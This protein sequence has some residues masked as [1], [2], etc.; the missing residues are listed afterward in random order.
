MVDRPERRLRATPRP[1]TE[2]LNVSGG[3]TLATKVADPGYAVVG[4]LWDAATAAAANPPTRT[5]SYD[6]LGLDMPFDTNQVSGGVFLNT[7]V[8]IS[9]RTGSVTF[10]GTKWGLWTD[11]AASRFR[12]IHIER[13]FPL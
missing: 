6:Q 13:G 1:P 5:Y 12:N 3:K 9:L 4:A 10:P 7:N 2:S 11:Q 8:G